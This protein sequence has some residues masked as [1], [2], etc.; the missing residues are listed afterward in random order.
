[1][2]YSARIRVF[3][4]CF[5]CG[6]F[7]SGGNLLNATVTKDTTK[8]Y[9]KVGNCGGLVNST[10][11]LLIEGFKFEPRWAGDCDI[12]LRAIRYHFIVNVM[13]FNIEYQGKLA[14][15]QRNLMYRRGNQGKGKGK[16]YASHISDE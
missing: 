15:Y 7:C 3:V 5:V 9:T 14:N 2:P 16:G 10:L 1:M 11:E 6:L 13:L 4:S 8:G 12:I